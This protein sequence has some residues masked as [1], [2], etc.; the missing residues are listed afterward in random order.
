LRP[1][2][3]QGVTFLA[4]DTIPHRNRLLCDD[5]GLG[6]SRQVIE[7]ADRLGFKWRLILCPASA[8][9]V[10][11]HEI[12][13]WSQRRSLVRVLRGQIT[14]DAKPPAELAS[15][16]RREGCDTITVIA[17]YDAFS[18]SRSAVGWLRWLCQVKWDVL[19]LDEI[20]RL[21]HSASNRTQRIY[22]RNC[23]GVDSL[24]QHAHRV[25][26]L[27]GTLTNNHNGETWT[28]LHALF[29]HT[30]LHHFPGSPHP[31]PMNEPEFTER[32]CDI[33]DTRFG[34]VVTGSKNIPDLRQ[35]IQGIVLRRR[36]QDVLPELPPMA[37]DAVPL[38]NVDTRPVAETDGFRLVRKGAEPILAQL[39]EADDDEFLE[40]LS[41][42]NPALASLRRA[43]G[44]AKTTRALDYITELLEGGVPKLLVF[45]HHIEVLHRLHLGL[46]G[47]APV[48]FQGS[49]PERVRTEAVK[50]FQNDPKCRVFLGQIDAAGTAL[51][52]TAASDVVF[53]ESSWVPSSN[54]QAASRAHRLGQRSAVL[55]RLLYAPDTLDERIN[56]IVARKARDFAQLWD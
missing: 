53:V 45:A 49:T 51:T 14:P 39:G 50:R 3:D 55:V 12:T 10:W 27:S 31:R 7:A 29:P 48:L 13:R 15:I 19:V 11:P 20:H 9:L 8:R 35:R 56:A 17:A 16:A 21:G 46:T 5:A 33:R 54:Y 34:R 28:H 40:I 47:F 18:A 52:L 23:D 25:W 41:H 1:Y 30:L 6:K 44:M 32:F 26:G 38:D 4:T 42:P 36:K 43:I 37:W 2:Q 24:I 22:G